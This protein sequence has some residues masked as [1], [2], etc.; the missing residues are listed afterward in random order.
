MGVGGGRSINIHYARL[1]TEQ[2]INQVRDRFHEDA[3]FLLEEALRKH[4]SRRIRGD[5][6]TARQVADTGALVA[7]GSAGILRGRQPDELAVEPPCFLPG[8]AGA[9]WPSHRALTGAHLHSPSPCE[10]DR[11]VYRE[12]VAHR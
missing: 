9:R 4:V 12:E 5:I 3:E 6:S 10:A 1:L 7:L 11:V 8:H 2:E